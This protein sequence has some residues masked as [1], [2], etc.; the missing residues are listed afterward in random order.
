MNLELSNTYEEYHRN[1]EARE[2]P[3]LEYLELDTSRQAQARGET[4]TTTQM[5][6]NDPS[7]AYEDVERV[8]SRN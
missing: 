4:I 3:A 1:I 2:N 7:A 8:T 5:N 6:L